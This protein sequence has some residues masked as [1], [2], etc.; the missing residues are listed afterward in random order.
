MTCKCPASPESLAARAA[1][2]ASLRAAAATAGSSEDSLA[3]SGVTTKLQ[4]SNS[5]SRGSQLRAQGLCVATVPLAR[6]C[7]NLHVEQ[8][9][10]V[11]PGLIVMATQCCC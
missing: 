3:H 7:T 1:A 4:G 8:L 10:I 5:R 2:K 6:R 9:H 11:I